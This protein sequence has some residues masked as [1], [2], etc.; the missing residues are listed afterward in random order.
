MQN[1]QFKYEENTEL[2]LKLTPQEFISLRN[3]IGQSINLC[4]IKSLPEVRIY[5]SAK[6]GE[7]VKKV[8]K[9][10]ISKGEVIEV[11]DPTKTFDI[12][13]LKISYD[14]NKITL[15]MLSSNALLER[16][17]KEHIDQGLAKEV[18]ETEA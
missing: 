10:Q 6:T 17:F 14:G 16:A 4:E 13:N 3:A 2:S 1:K 12:D 7:P 9:D 18:V 11:T 15:D 5:I 8:S